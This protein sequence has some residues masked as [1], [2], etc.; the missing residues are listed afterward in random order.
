[1]IF[2]RIIKGFLFFC[3][4]AGVGRNWLKERCDGYKT[5]TIYKYYTLQKAI[6]S[7]R[8]ERNVAFHYE[9]VADLR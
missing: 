9:L 8:C 2:S 5:V 7:G 4:L 3:M 6:T 1:M